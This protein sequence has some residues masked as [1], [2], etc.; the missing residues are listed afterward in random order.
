MTRTL[1]IHPSVNAIL[2]QIR[3]MRVWSRCVVVV[4]GTERGVSWTPL[5]WPEHGRFREAG[6][7]ERLLPSHSQR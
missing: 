1:K 5:C 2:K 7:L 3:D 4:V 6:P